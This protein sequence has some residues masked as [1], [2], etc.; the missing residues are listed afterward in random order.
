M[1]WKGVDASGLVGSLATMR[2]Q[3]QYLAA[4]AEPTVA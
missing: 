2:D 1:G 3:L 4:V